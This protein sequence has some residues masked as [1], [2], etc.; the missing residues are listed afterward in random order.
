[1]KIDWS[2]G[3]IMGMIP[4]ISMILCSFLLSKS[5]KSAILE[6]IFQYYCAGL[7]V[8]AV[9]LELVPSLLNNKDLPGS[10]SII[11]VFFGFSFA[12]FLIHGVDFVVNSIENETLSNVEKLNL[13][14]F[15]KPNET[16]D[17]LLDT[18]S[19]IGY[20]STDEVSPLPASNFENFQKDVEMQVNQS[21]IERSSNQWEEEPVIESLEAMSYPEHRRLLITA[22][23][24]VN[25]SIEYLFSKIF[26]LV[27]DKV[28]S[29]ASKRDELSE[30]V[31]DQVHRLQYKIDKTRR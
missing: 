15:S 6:A 14:L 13:T 29:S 31:D 27:D 4:C 10:T 12:I 7:L 25:G 30:I 23:Q 18:D 24:D 3:I 2:S 17:K 21:W 1:M 28:W 8:S 19:T 11:G 16:L 5:S 20:Q 22:I 9:A 26:E